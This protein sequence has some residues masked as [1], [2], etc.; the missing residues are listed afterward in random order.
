MADGVFNISKGF[1]NEYVQRI[2]SNDP[3][4]AELAVH[5]WAGT[6]VTDDVMRGY[7]TVA[8]IEAGILNEATFTGYA[9]TQPLN[10]TDT[11]QGL[12][13]A[14]DHAA[15]NFE[16]DFDDITWTAAG[17]GANDTLHRLTVSYDEP[18]TDVDATMIPVCFYD[19]NVLTDGSDLTAQLDANGFFRAA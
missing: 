13:Q 4:T 10:I 16:S 12:T 11:G 9:G 15:D 1:V 7:E 14:V 6:D 2:L 3:A 8:A 18:G 5:L 19:F 17:N